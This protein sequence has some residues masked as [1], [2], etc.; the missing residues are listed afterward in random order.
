MKLALQ[1]A[2]RNLRAE[3]AYPNASTCVQCASIDSASSTFRTLAK[4]SP[5]P[6]YSYRLFVVSKEAKSFAIKQIHTLSQKHR[7]GGH[8]GYRYADAK[9]H[10]NN[11]FIINTCESVSKQRTL[12]TFRM[13]TYAKQGE[14]GVIVN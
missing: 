4:A 7:V 11:P 3:P 6:S 2:R 14:G 13:N 8:H 9:P 12:T 5:V 1:P 10:G